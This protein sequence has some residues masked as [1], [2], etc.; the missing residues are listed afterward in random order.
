[1]TVFINAHAVAEHDHVVVRA[2]ARPVAVEVPQ[3]ELAQ[4]GLLP[5]DAVGGRG[6]LPEGGSI[7]HPPGAERI[8]LVVNHV[9]VSVVQTGFPIAVLVPQG[10]ARKLAG[11]ADAARNAGCGGRVRAHDR[12]HWVLRERV[13]VLPVVLGGREAAEKKRRRRAREEG[14]GARYHLPGH[15][16]ARGSF[17]G[18]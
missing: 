12:E 5:R 17:H 15:C 8:G 9:R 3:I 16:A 7:P 4:V 11:G 13:G 14:G 18:S 6:V 2:E 10:V 1:M